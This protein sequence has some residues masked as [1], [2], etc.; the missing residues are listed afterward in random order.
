M[1][2]IDPHLHLF[3]LSQGD[4]HWL[5]A[6]HLPFWSDKAVINRSFQESD[7]VLS[8]P[9]ELAGFIHIEAGFDNEQPWR[10]LASLEQ[11][12]SKPFCAIASVDLTL[13]SNQFQQYLTRVSQHPSFIGIRHILDEQALDLLTN[14]QALS[15]I[16]TLND[17][18]TSIN[19]KLVFEA[20]LALSEDVAVNALCDVISKKPHLNFIINHAGFPPANTLNPNWQHW[21]D[22][23]KKVSLHHNTAIKCSGWEM[24]DR[25]YQSA[26]LSENLTC[27]FNH[28]G[29]KK[30]MLA[31][32]F[33]LCL[34]SRSS[35][36][37][38]WQH[39]ID[40]AF[41]HGLS[42]NEKN[43]LCYDN[44]LHWYSIKI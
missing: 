35:Y 9:L 7:L 42:Q 38:Y 40:C 33:P 28:F 14:K 36:H 5:K 6:E 1:K 4:Y 20:Q 41:F 18:A 3:N 15:N 10:E 27:I 21:K 25:S 8:T 26:W 32:N 23:L 34:F 17:F 30:M 29:A 19:Q 16:K 2:I 12:C 44:A 24:T 37:H 13:A 22:N 11:S 31:S 39:T 43:A